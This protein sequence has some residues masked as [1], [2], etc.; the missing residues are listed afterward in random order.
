[1]CFPASGAASLV[2]LVDR[3]TISPS[4]HFSSALLFKSDAVDGDCVTLICR[5]KCSDY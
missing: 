5:L 1:M 2:D 4:H 3:S